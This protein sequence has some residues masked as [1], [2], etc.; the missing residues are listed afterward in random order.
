[1]EISDFFRFI[2]NDQSANWLTSR[3]KRPS[4]VHS[5]RDPK[6]RKKWLGWVGC[7][8]EERLVGSKGQLQTPDPLTRLPGPLGGGTEIASGPA[9]TSLPHK[10]L[11]TR[12]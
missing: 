6:G 12:V 5:H 1:M 11:S 2:A 4:R 7:T 8:G 9:A 3:A 10:A